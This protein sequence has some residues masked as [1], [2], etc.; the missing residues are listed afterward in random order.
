MYLS[1][2]YMMIFDTATLSMTKVE[3]GLNC[4]VNVEFC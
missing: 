3:K 2:W 1:W 4:H